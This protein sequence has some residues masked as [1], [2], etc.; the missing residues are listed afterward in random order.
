MSRRAVPGAAGCPTQG[1]RHIGPVSA[2]LTNG[3]V[4][5]T[6]SM[7]S[8]MVN[9]IVQRGTATKLCSA[10]GVEHSRRNSTIFRYWG[11]LAADL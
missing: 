10:A 2:L 3:P 1:G 7:R 9:K 4:C 8:V 5:R 11:F 6:T